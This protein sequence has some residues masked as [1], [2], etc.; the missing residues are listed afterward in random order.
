[1]EN[2]NPVTKPAG[3]NQYSLETIDAIQGQ[4]TPD[5][6]RGYLKGNAFKYL[7]RYRK[8]GGV[9]DLQKAAWYVNR[10]ASYEEKQQN[11]AEHEKN[12]KFNDNDFRFYEC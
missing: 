1:M 11:A 9:Q 3:Y 5:E 10:L 4:C 8:K 6:Y 12:T 7:A 2:F